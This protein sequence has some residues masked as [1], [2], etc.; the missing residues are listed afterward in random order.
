MERGGEDVWLLMS[1]IPAVSC[2]GF[3]PS[4]LKD[5]AKASD[6]REQGEPRKKKGLLLLEWKPELAS[7]V[8]QQRLICRGFCE[9]ETTV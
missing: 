4:G 9:S 6:K 5:D 8:V 7:R 3:V 1:C 2:T